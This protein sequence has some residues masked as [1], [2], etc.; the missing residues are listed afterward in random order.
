MG[1]EKSVSVGADILAHHKW[2]DGKG[3]LQRLKGGEI[4]KKRGI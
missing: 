1:T 3:Y 4:E 2:W